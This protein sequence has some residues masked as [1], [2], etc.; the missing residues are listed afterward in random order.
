MS[1]NSVPEQRTMDMRAPVNRGKAY[2]GPK[3]LVE[4]KLLTLVRLPIVSPV[5]LIFMLSMVIPVMMQRNTV[6]F[7]EWIHSQL[8]SVFP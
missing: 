2:S 7:F 6:E 5:M 3:N 8:L 4:W 1:S